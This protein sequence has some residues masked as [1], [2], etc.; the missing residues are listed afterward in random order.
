M[1][2]KLEDLMSGKI[3]EILNAAKVNELLHK[4][5]E[6]DKHKNC[7]IGILAIIG[8]VAAVAAIAY[9]VYH[10]FTPD[11]LDDF[12]DDFED[13]YE[14]DFFEDDDTEENASASEGAK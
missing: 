12:E 3:D 11:Y 14:D 9:A 2:G 1:A 10:H 5:E 6:E 8:I 4:K 13:D 7:I